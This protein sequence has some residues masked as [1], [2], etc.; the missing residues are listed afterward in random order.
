[1]AGGDEV[2][3]KISIGNFRWGD[4]GKFGVVSGKNACMGWHKRDIMSL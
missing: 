3:A 4:S 2:F 1:M